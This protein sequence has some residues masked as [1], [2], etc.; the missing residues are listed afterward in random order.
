MK[1]AHG[2]RIRGIPSDVGGAALAFLFE[3][4]IVVGLAVAAL[5]IAAVVIAVN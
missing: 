2:R 1:R 4:M 3:I 5:L